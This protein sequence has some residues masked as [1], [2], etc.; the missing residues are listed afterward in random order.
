MSMRYILH[1]L[2]GSGGSSADFQRRVDADRA[3]DVEVIGRGLEHV[4]VDRGELLGSPVALDLHL[5]LDLLISG[6]HR[7]AEAEKAAQVELAPGADLEAVER[8]ALERGAGD[9]ADGDAG[10]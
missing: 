5:V 8:D 7:V 2:L 1:L 6:R 4:V 3:A 10:V 9:V